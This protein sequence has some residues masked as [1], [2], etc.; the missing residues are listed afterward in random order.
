MNGSGNILIVDDNPNNLQVLGSILAQA[1][2]KVRPA[3]SGEIA[4]RA[5]EVATPDLIL[6]DIRMPGISG[7][8]TCERLKASE[9]NRDIPVIFISAMHDIED[10]LKGFQ[11]G[12]VDYVAKPFQEE[13]VLA[14]V[15]AHIELYRLKRNLGELVLQR[16]QELSQS[17]ARYRVLF[18]N[19]PLAVI[20]YDTKD[21]HI[22]AVNVACSRILGYASAELVGQ[23][24]GF[25]VEHDQREALHS[26]ARNLTANSNETAFTGRLHFHHSDGH[27]LEAEGIVQRIDY[28]SYCA[29][30]L[31][32]QDVTARRQAEENLQLAAKE[33]QRQLEKT[34]YYDALTGLP[35]RTQ[36]AERMRQGIEQAQRTACWMA[37]CYLDLDAFKTVNETFGQEVGDQL[38][39]KVGEC[40]RARLCGGDT[41]ARTGGDEF[42]LLLMGA[43]S[44]EELERFIHDLQANLSEPFCLDAATVTLSACIGITIYPQDNADPDTLLRHADQAMV[45]AKQSGRGRCKHFDLEDNR[46]ARARQDTIKRMRTALAQREFVLYYQPKVN[47]KQSTVIGAEALIRWQHPERGLLPPGMFLPEIEGDELMIELGDW[48]IDEA[49][50]QMARWRAEGLD[51]TVSVNVAA[52]QLAQENFIDRLRELLHIHP[53][54]AAGR[55]ELEVLET[56][57]LDDIGKVEQIIVACRQLGVGFSLDDFGTGYSSLTYLRRLSAD[58]LKIDQSFIRDMMEDPGDL[59]IVSGVIGLAAAFQRKVIAEGVETVAHGKL[60][61]SLGCFLVQG[62]GIARPMPAHDL[63]AWTKSWP[64]PAWRGVLRSYPGTYEL[65]LNVTDQVTQIT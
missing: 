11:V 41:V 63:P 33:H 23:S 55:L 25:A 34:A 29:Q 17:E 12:G 10:K 16:T 56:S 8:E 27:I 30:I 18:E 35:N 6:L 26:L 48:V 24:V 36:L 57:K 43:K 38:L 42:T 37:V 64:D 50:S 49:L 40:L 13:E 7:Y 39:V 60:L 15:K 47:L 1:G 4:L 2:F 3:L 52:Q 21:W 31:M 9:R 53:T 22:L 14:R 65:D 5:V 32:L 46:R 59:A 62:Y 54:T 44:I 61:L 20:I 19:S 58:T 45:L 28:P 51:L